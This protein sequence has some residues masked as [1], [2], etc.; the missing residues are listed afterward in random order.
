M[1]TTI[2]DFSDVLE[3]ARQGDEHAWTELYDSVAAQMLGYLRGRGA[4]D[5]EGLLGDAFLQVAR[6]LRTFEGNESG[7]RSWVFAVAHNRLIDERRQLA[8]RP[9]EAEYPVSEPE[10]PPAPVDV[11]AE[12]I[13][14]VDRSSIEGLLNTLS[15]DQRDVVLLRVLAGLSAGETGAVIGKSVGTVRVLQHRALQALRDRMATGDVTL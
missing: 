5:P 12:A 3:A 7:F 11:E 13:R 15:E 8:R 14:A 2:A 1:A 6:N 9:G 10:T 4:A